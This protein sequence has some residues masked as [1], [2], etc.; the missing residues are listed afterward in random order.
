M[1]LYTIYTYNNID[2]LRSIQ[3]ELDVYRFEFRKTK[4]L[5]DS[6]P[7]VCIDITALLYYLDLQKGDTESAYTN[8]SDITDETVVIANKSIAYKGIELLPYLFNETQPYSKDDPEKTD[9][10]TLWKPQRK[11]VYTYN[12]R[13]EFNHIIAYLN[14]NDIPVATFSQATNEAKNALD[15]FSKHDKLSIID[16]TSVVQSISG[17]KNLIYLMEQIFSSLP[18]VSVIVDRSVVDEL[19]D[20]F[21][22]YFEDVAPIHDL[23]PDIHLSDDA[24]A[25]E[26]L[27]RIVDLDDSELDNFFSYFSQNLVGHSNFKVNV[28]EAIRNFIIL[29]KIGE[30]KILS[31]FLFGESG[32]GKT[33]VARTFA[34]GLRKNGYF[35]KIN[36]QNYS[37][38]NALNSLIGSPAGYIGCDKGELSTKLSKSKIGLILC[39]EFEKTTYPVSVFFLELL[40][41]GKF[42][43]SMSREYD[44]DGYIIVFTSNIVNANDFNSKIPPELRTRF[45]L[46]CEFVPPCDEDI[47][48]FISLLIKKIQEDNKELYNMLD[49]ADIEYLKSFDYDSIGSLREIKKKFYNLFVEL[50]ARK[51]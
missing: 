7:K 46:I 43:D 34:N 28:E 22:M 40:E 15:S 29:N 11:A 21:P 42:T 12:G 20:Y 26:S 37:S 1:R 13:D 30:Q 18:K 3:A 38:Q 32:V 51:K 19:L 47:K 45:D 14:E 27:R 8:F 25:E 48:C 50:T 41:E 33:E 17:S 2:E 24:E 31:I 6:N 16:L 9:D 49:E 39:D 10:L 35:T 36:F 5:L 4:A 44:L 23:L